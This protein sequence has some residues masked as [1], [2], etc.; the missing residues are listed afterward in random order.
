MGVRYRQHTAAAAKS[1]LESAADCV[2]ES[3][4][5]YRA[6]KHPQLG[7]ALKELGGNFM[8]C[9]S[10]KNDGYEFEFEYEYE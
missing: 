3:A 6:L 4:S 10:L 1:L 8:G 9:Q 2:A 5:L 7:K